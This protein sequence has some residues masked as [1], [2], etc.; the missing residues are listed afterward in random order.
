MENENSGFVQNENR[1]ILVLRK[2]TI[3]EFLFYGKRESQY[4]R[5]FSKPRILVLWK[6][7]LREFSFYRKQQ[8]SFCGKRESENSLFVENE[9]PRILV[10]WK[11][12]IRK[13]VENENSRFVGNKNSRILILWKTRIG[14]ISFC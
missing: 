1:R 2:T 10:L 3:R 7:R 14:E 13:F 9:T 11:T 4:S 12:R 8:F 6:K 5:F